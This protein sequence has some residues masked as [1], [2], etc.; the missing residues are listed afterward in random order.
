MKLITDIARYFVGVLFI[1][2][3]IVKAND[4]LGFS[5]KLEEYFEEFAKLGEYVGFLEQLFHFCHEYA[6]PQAIFI[7]ILEVILGVAILVR[8]KTRL[9]ATLLLI[10]IA[11]FTALTFAS[12]YFGIVKTC[13]CFG[14]AIPLTAWESFYKDVILSVF[15]LIVFVR[16]KQ[17]SIAETG[18]NDFILAGV[19]SLVMLQLSYDLEWFFPFWFIGGTFITFFLI[20]LVEHRKAPFFVTILATVA[21]SFFTFYT[22]SYLPIKDFRA[23]APGKSIAEQ[24]EGVPDKLKYFYILKDKE[25]GNEKEFEKFPENYQDKYEYVDSRTEV[26]EKGIEP[27]I[28]DF[29]VMTAE[30]EDLTED[31][32]QSENFTFL[33]VAYDL[34]I[35]VLQPQQRINDLASALMEKGYRFTGLTA[36]L[37][38]QAQQ[39]VIANGSP[40]NYLYCDQIVLKTI[41]RSNPGLMLIKDGNV[42]GKWHYNDI[43]ELQVLELEYLNQD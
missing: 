7:V 37:P 1:F 14:D 17:I 18:M 13:G 31:F 35:S 3:G 22:F 25:T 20:R 19:G 24:M 16:Q 40:F 15:I 30:G 41:I 6:L 2:S 34:N 9:T 26:I 11:F 33:L 38:D 21:M 10:L 23:Y 27:K 29:S 4:P 42:Y 12:A 32:L 39:F 36:S 8:F 43:P 5:Y 28:M